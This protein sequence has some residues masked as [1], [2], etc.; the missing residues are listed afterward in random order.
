ME[1]NT[2]P[3]G[4]Q[5]TGAVATEDLVEGRFVRLTSHTWDEDFGSLTDLP[6]VAYPT[7]STA[8]KDAR[9]CVTFTAPDKV[10]DGANPMYIP[11]P[12]Y[13]Y[14]LR[15][16]FDRTTN[17]PMSSTTVRL[18]W[19][20]NMD[21]QTIPSGYKV[22]LFGHDSVVT[23]PSGNWV[24]NASAETPGAYMEVLNS[25]DDGANKGMLSYAASFDDSIV[26]Q[27][28]RYNSTTGD[29]TVRIIGR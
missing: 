5:P 8:A 16:G 19:P 1:I 15:G 2:F 24:Y 7:T 18:T 23:I 26:A 25:G 29:L 22:L 27:V 12:S 10:V 14:A 28:V 11:T 21:T 6:G 20:G 17:L 9:F 13:S 4:T 3:Q